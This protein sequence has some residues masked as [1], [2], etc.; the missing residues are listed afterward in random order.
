MGQLAAQPDNILASA[1]TVKDF[2]LQLGD[3]LTLRLRDSRTGEQRQVVFHYAG[4]VKE[5]PTAPKDSFFVANA[6]Y[7][8]QS[9]GNP[10]P[11]AYLIDTGSSSAR[12][13]AG[14]ITRVLGSAA[15]V[16][17]IADSRREVGSS[18]TAVDLG[19]LTKVELGFALLL[20]AAAT[21]LLLALELAERRRSFAIAK[22]L[23][24]RPGQTGAFVRVEAAVV[25]VAGL[26]LGTAAGAALTE[27]L[28]KVLT[29]VFD[30]PPAHLGIPG[31]YLA[32]VAV[33]ALV[34]AG[35]G[36]PTHGLGQSRP[37]H[38]R[39]PRALNL[40]SVGQSFIR[41]VG[42]SVSRS[43]GQSPSPAE[44]PSS[45][46]SQSTGSASTIHSPARR[47]IR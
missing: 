45:T 2:Q 44:I 47:T 19:G 3:Q 7:L 16:T 8:A 38:R 4:V 37:G 12:Q 10:R 23:G 22:A 14:R 42:Q 27:V 1:E 41:S 39:H 31:L 34:A 29:G 24:A 13:V 17:N 9:S 33:G 32:A 46:A 28:V 43:V 15:S 20:A 36:R 26:V 11:D 18:L 6:S 21:G 25:T 5:F 30:P 40:R 35:G